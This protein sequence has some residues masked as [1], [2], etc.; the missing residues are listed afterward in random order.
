MLKVL[1]PR[2]DTRVALAT[3]ASRQACQIEGLSWNTRFT[4]D[5]YIGLVPISASEGD[6][7]YVGEELLLS[8]E[9]AQGHL[10]PDTEYALL[11]RTLPDEQRL[12]YVLHTTSADAIPFVLERLVRRIVDMHM[13]QVLPPEE[14]ARFDNSGIER[15]SYEQIKQKLKHNLAFLDAVIQCD[16]RFY[17]EICH[18]LMNNL[19]WLINEPDYQGYFANRLQ[20]RH[21][22]RCHGDLKTPNIWI[23]INKGQAADYGIKILDAIDFND[24]Y[25]YID[26]LSDFAM[27][28]I[29]IEFCTHSSQHADSMIEHYL[30]LTRQN[31]EP[32][33]RVLNYYLVEKAIINGVV[34]I[35]YDQQPNRGLAFLQLAKRRMDELVEATLSPVPSS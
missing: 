30:Q 9:E 4:P 8:A 3:Y 21:I 25:C 11:M 27:L 7:I 13:Y 15:G 23:D 34:N 35:L 17:S 2:Q 16:T 26:V 1:R 22:K 28:V 18:N 10:S 14:P 19:L 29:D 31:D 24:H 12:D 32:S 5:V 33:R 20:N 6:Q